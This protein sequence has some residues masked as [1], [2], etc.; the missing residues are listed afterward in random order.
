M[1]QDSMEV[2][3]DIRPETDL[4]D[5]YIV[6]RV[7]Q[8]CPLGY[9]LEGHILVHEQTGVRC[10]RRAL[11]FKGLR[12]RRDHHDHYHYHRDGSITIKENVVVLYHYC[13]RFS[14]EAIVTNDKLNCS[15]DL[16]TDCDFGVGTYATKKQPHAFPDIWAILR[17]NYPRA[18]AGR[19]P[20]DPGFPLAERA[21]FCIPMIA[22]KA[23]TPAFPLTDPYGERGAIRES[24]DRYGPF[25]F[26]KNDIW[27]LSAVHADLA[28]DSA[29]DQALVALHK[30][31]ESGNIRMVSRFLADGVPID[32]LDA[33]GRPPL[34]RA[35]IRGQA[36]IV[37]LLLSEGA[38]ASMADHRGET[39]LHDAVSEGH[40]NAVALLL[41]AGASTTSPGRH[42]ETPLCLARKRVQQYGTTGKDKV[43]LDC[44]MRIMEM[45]ERQGL[46]CV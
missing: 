43:P 16:T 15:T 8:S 41:S 4:L 35:A 29:S 45:L 31:A 10:L 42:G 13:P 3:D 9:R 19:N 17:N 33:Y 1:E 11:L 14:F 18:T 2:D 40:E 6:D 46:P 36:H 44:Y 23:W 21:E 34:R 20:G 37:Q 24:N 38:D 26:L 30:A 7:G 27:V 28:F 32:A 25:D 22:D 5:A 39:A 12:G